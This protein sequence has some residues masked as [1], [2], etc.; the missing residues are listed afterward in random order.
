MPNFP[1][2]NAIAPNAGI[3]A[4]T[5]GAA[6]LDVP[7][8]LSAP[9]AVPLTLT[10]TIT[11]GTATFSKQH[12]G[13][14]YGGATSGTITF[15]VGIIEKKF[16]IPIW[17]DAHADPDETFTI[18]IATTAPATTVQITNATMTATMYGHS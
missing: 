12:T 7:V 11:P 10:Y 4:T 9:L 17:P 1:T 6:E 14:D 15:A 16:A 13:G 18:T 8:T 3:Q 5:S 2:V